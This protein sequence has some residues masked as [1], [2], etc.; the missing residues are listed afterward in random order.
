MYP[1]KCQ[2]EQAKCGIYSEQH[3]YS[4]ISKN[5][6]MSFAAKEVTGDHDVK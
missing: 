1:H 2:T 5:E 4:V 3:F 6:I